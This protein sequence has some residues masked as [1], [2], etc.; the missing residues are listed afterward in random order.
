VGGKP[1]IG[2]RIESALAC[3]AIGRVIVSTDDEEI[4]DV[5][6]R[7]GAD[8]PFLRPKE[9]AQDDTPML[10]VA[11][12]LLDWLPEEPE[13]LFLLQPTSPLC[14]ADDLQNAIQLARQKNADAVVS[15]AE[16]S[17]HPYWMKTIGADGYL[18]NFLADADIPSRRQDLPPAYAL[19]GAIYLIRPEILRAE[20]SFVPART[21]PYVMP[22][23]RSLDVDSAWDLHL[24]DL[25]LQEA[26][27]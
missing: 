22:P 14:G 24:V 8:V 7:F 26:R 25:I 15:V 21:V 5:A 19:N 13:Y 27:K 4:A 2:W 16:V 18:Q 6:R 1:L 20:G 3:D 9:L 12:H 17:K 23:E 11:L 10:D